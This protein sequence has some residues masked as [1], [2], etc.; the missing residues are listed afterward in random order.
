MEETKVGAILSM[1]SFPMKSLVLPA[2]RYRNSIKNPAKGAWNLLY[3]NRACPAYS[4]R[5]K[6]KRITAVLFQNKIHA[7]LV[8]DNSAHTSV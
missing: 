7:K 6:F 8:A 3:L 1:L 2:A 5:I 4:K